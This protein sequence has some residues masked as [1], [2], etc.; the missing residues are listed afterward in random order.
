MFAEQKGGQC[1]GLWNKREK[2]MSE[3]YRDGSWARRYKIIKGV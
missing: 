2:G 3:I 1:P